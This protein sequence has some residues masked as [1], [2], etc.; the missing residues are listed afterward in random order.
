MDLVLGNADA[1]EERLSR[2]PLVRVRVIG[3]HVPLVAPPDVPSRP[4]EVVLG[5]ALV[6]GPDLGAAR[7]GDAK[8]LG[9]DGPV[10]DPGS[11]VL[12]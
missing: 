3:G 12:G 2:E 1:V 7:Q 11:S 10:G 6:D 8:R 4:V 9:L 5:E